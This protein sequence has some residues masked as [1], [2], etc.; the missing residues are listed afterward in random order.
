MGRFKDTRTWAD[1]LNSEARLQNTVFLRFFLDQISSEVD[2][3]ESEAVERSDELSSSN[4]E[5][6]SLAPDS[7]K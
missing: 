5:D 4:D 6:V 1:F 3:S 2:A 7:D